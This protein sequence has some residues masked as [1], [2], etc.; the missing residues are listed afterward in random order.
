MKKILGVT[1]AAAALCAAPAFA[2]TPFGEYAS[3]SGFGTLGAVTSDNSTDAFVRDGAPTGAKGKPSWNVD[4]K[5]GVQLDA[6]ANDWLSATV[7]VL[8]EQRYTPEVSAKFEWAFVKIKPVDGLNIR[9]GRTAPAMFMV[10]DSRNVGFANTW[11]RPP[12]EVYSLAG[13]KNL[14]GVDASYRLELAGTSLTLAVLAGNSQFDNVNSHLQVKKM[15]GLNLVW[16]SDYGSF[17]LGR[18]I[19]DVHVPGFGPGGSEV[20]DGYTFTGLGYQFDNG[21]WVVGAEHVERAADFFAPQ[22]NS[23]GWYVMGGRRFDSV[24]PYVSA[25]GTKN[26]SAMNVLNGEQSTYALGLRWDAQ[27]GVAVKAQFEHADPKGTMGVSFAPL[28]GAV[29]SKTNA[30]SLVVDFVF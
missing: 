19:A 10:S 13:M 29:R 7:Q 24:L 21:D 3:L 8:A 20:V 5:L 9:V 23:K 15:R 28:V 6:K 1:L 26:Q 14:T 22:V 2:A 25:A 16:D 11:V 17:R 12:N 18:V 4:S 30:L 27:S